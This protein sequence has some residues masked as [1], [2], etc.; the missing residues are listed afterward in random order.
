MY[1]SRQYMAPERAVQPLMD[2]SQY[3]TYR[4]SQ[5][6]DTTLKAACKDAGCDAWA[7]GWQTTVDESTQ[8]GQQQAAYI[9]QKSGRTFKEQRTEAGLTVFTFEPFQRCFAE[10]RTRPQK[11]VELGGDFRGN[12][13]G[14]HRVH[15]QAADWVESFAEHQDKIAT[16]IERG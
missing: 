3:K 4:I 11:F 15:V 13:R 7:H 5:G 16:A 6:R 8:L 1:T 12:P 9:R 10:H 14:E 2:P